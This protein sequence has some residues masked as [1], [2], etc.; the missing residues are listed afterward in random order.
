MS[1]NG[2]MLS[3]ATQCAA[4][5]GTRPVSVLEVHGKA[6]TSV[7]YAGGSFEGAAVPG[8]LASATLWA[9]HNGCGAPVKGAARSVLRHGPFYTGS[10]TDVL[11]FPGCA[12]NTGVSLWS[13]TGLSSDVDTSTFTAKFAGAVLDFLAAHVP[14]VAAAPSPDAG[15]AVEDMGAPAPRAGRRC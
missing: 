7:P 15:F 14:A 11:D 5:S 1:L 4:F 8:A 3:N 10:D 12:G 2:A 6:D 13:V 9:Q